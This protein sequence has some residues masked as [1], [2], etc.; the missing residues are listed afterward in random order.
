MDSNVVF[1]GGADSKIKIW[2]IEKGVCEREIVG[3]QSTVTELILFEN[4]FDNKKNNFMLLSCGSSD[5]LLRLSNPVSP[6]NNGLMIDERLVHDWATSCSPV[7]Q[8]IRNNTDDSIRVAIV[9]QDSKEK[10]FLVFKIRSDY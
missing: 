5:E 2:N 1:S 4:P 3:H 9:T 8:I 6:I 7:M 10:F